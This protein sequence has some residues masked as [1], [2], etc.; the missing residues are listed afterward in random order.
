MKSI[1]VILAALTVFF[2]PLLV[3]EQQQAAPGLRIEA[4][5]VTKAAPVRATV[6]RKK[7]YIAKSQQLSSG[8]GDPRYQCDYN[9]QGKPVSCWCNWSDDAADCAGFVLTNP[10]GND[11]CWTSN[12]PGEYGCDCQ[13]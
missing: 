1:L 11:A 2:A 6:S 9:Q 13:N 7:D 8:S 3:A 5:Q 10:C 4:K 12:V